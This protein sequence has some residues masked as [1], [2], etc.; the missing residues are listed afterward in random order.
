MNKT[1]IILSLLFFLG[2]CGESKT[3]NSAAIDA[4]AASEKL[5]LSDGST[6]NYVGKMLYSED[7]NNEHGSTRLNKIVIA[8][9][10]K[11]VE[12]LLYTQLLALGYTRKV[13]DSKEGTF[14]VHY[15]KKGQPTIGA[16]F[17]ETAKDDSLTTN[18]SI[19]WKT[20]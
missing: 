20:K 5:T 19:Y 7:R 18:M 4:S 9:G 1:I 2:A 12:N 3:E 14:K 11:K 6:L 17:L 13:M 8:S 10:A 15:Y 16:V